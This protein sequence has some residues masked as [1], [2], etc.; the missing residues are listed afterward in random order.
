VFGAPPP[1]GACESDSSAQESTALS[2]TSAPLAQPLHLA[3]PL[4]LH[5]RGSTTAPD[6]TWVATVSDVAPDGRSAQLTAGW[7][8]QSMRALDRARSVLMPDGGTIVP[9][10][11]F[12]RASRLAVRSGAIDDLD[13]EIFNTDAVVAAGHRLRLTVSSGDAPH[14]L[15]PLATQLRSGGAIV[16]VHSSP[17]QPSVLAAQTAPLEPVPTASRT[18]CPAARDSRRRR[19]TARAAAAPARRGCRRRAG[20]KRRARPSS[21]RPA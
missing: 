8:V 7:L 2:Y 13:I 15:A 19:P 20:R 16:T 9:V 5:L 1:G 4:A 18:T 10:H 21:A 6:T 3:G 11:P 17:A 14:L 12:T